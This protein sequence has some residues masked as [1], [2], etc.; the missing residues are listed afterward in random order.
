M[1]ALLLRPQEPSGFCFVFSQASDLVTATSHSGLPPVW[2]NFS[3]R[4]VLEHRLLIDGGKLTKPE[5]P[6]IPTPEPNPPPLPP[7]PKPPPPIE[8]PIMLLTSGTSNKS[9]GD[10]GRE[11]A[12]FV[13]VL[14]TFRI[15]TLLLIVLRFLFCTLCFMSALACCP[16]CVPPPGRKSTCFCACCTLTTMIPAKMIRPAWIAKLKVN[17]PPPTFAQAR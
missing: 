17:P 16:C 14:T 6:P 2:R 10:S 1:A 7:L 15:G 3:N 13:L 9:G 5:A 11:I 4:S 8:P 12:A